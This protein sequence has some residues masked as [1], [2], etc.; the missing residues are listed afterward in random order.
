ML[1]TIAELRAHAHA[2]AAETKQEFHHFVDY[3]ERK[4]NAKPVLTADDPELI[5]LTQSGTSVSTLMDSAIGAA[6]G[7]AN[8]ATGN[9]IGA[10]STL[11]ESATGDDSVSGAPAQ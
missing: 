3:V 4:E 6:S 11:G 1:L 5:D 9:V 7:F 8:E 10:G 2:F